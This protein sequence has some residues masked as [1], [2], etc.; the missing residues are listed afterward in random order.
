MLGNASDYWRLLGVLPKRLARALVK[1][2]P[3]KPKI[4]YSRHL[5]TI[6]RQQMIEDRIF[7][8]PTHLEMWVNYIIQLTTDLFKIET[9]ERIPKE[10]SRQ[11][12]LQ[13]MKTETVDS[14]ASSINFQFGAKDLYPVP[15]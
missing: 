12:I 4:A 8:P 11:N 5:S 10:F 9:T 7:Y 6:A 2:I 15:H 13:H 14:A 3:N 1:G